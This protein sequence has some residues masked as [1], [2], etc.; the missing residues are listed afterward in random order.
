MMLERLSRI[1]YFYKSLFAKYLVLK[2]ISEE[3]DV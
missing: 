2:A 3:L 1:H